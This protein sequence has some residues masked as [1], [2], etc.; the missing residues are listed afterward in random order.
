MR[1]NGLLCSVS[2]E[3]LTMKR[4]SNW[5]CDG[6]HD[7]YC[8]HIVNCMCCFSPKILKEDLKDL[9]YCYIYE[10]SKFTLFTL[11]LISAFFILL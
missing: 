2:D 6:T 5:F 8:Y 1:K 10:T 4:V 7:G 3:A 9:K 11:L